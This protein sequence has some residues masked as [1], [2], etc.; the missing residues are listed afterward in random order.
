[1]PLW[2]LWELRRP[3]VTRLSFGEKGGPCGSAASKVGRTPF[4]YLA[5][6][7]ENGISFVILKHLGHPLIQLSKTQLR[8]QGRV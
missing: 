1:M 5:R 3:N 7:L 6:N 8:R 2:A 4:L